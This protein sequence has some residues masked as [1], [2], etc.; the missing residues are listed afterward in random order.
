MAQVSVGDTVLIHYNGKLSDGTVFGSSNGGD[1]LQLTVGENTIIPK[2]EQSVV[3]MAVGD[4]TTVE[5]PADD[6]YGQRRD[7]AVQTVQRTQI[8]EN[9]DVSVGNRLQATG[10]DG[11]ALVV[12]VVESDD[13]TVTL[14]ANHPLAGEDLTFEIE[15]VEIVEP[16]S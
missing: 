8:P 13:A 1:P 2:L 4:T 14:D 15:L 10:P 7:D 9:I 11:E 6:A 16:T 5:V 3:G 12:T